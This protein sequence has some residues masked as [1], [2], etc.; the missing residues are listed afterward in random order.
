MDLRGR[1]AAGAEGAAAARNQRRP[2]RRH[3][4]IRRQGRR[5]LIAV[6]VHRPCHHRAPPPAKRACVG[7]VPPSAGASGANLHQR[8]HGRLK[9][10]ALLQ[11]GRFSWWR[12]E[13]Q[14]LRYLSHSGDKRRQLQSTRHLLAAFHIVLTLIGYGGFSE[15]RRAPGTKLV[16]DRDNGGH[17]AGG[18]SRGG[19][20]ASG[21]RHKGFGFVTFATARALKRRCKP[22]RAL[23]WN[24][25]RYA[26]AAQRSAMRFLL[27]RAQAR[28]LGV[29]QVS[30]CQ[31][32]FHKCVMIV[33]FASRHRNAKPGS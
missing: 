19:M 25:V 32:S 6:H 4:H 30:Q 13:R 5:H 31:S 29:A 27:V 8:W 18:G 16:M 3:A 33:G 12:R 10:R 20:G 7:H 26:L 15:L 21:Q 11:R 2:T 17:G 1:T 23:N 28:V 24:N 9:R 14:L 22:W